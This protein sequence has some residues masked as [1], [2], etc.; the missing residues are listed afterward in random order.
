LTAVGQA[1]IRASASVSLWIGFEAEAKMLLLVLLQ[2][3]LLHLLLH[4]SA[5]M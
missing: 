1:F 2:A 4:A 5:S 3:V